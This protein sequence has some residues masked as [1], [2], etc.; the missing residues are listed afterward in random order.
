MQVIQFFFRYRFVN[1]RIS[2]FQL[3]LLE[4]WDVANMQVELGQY[5]AYHRP[6]FFFFFQMFND[7]ICHVFHDHLLTMD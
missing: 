1:Q 3:L 2:H 6:N 4:F 7:M 5:N